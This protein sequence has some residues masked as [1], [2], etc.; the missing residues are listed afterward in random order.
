MGSNRGCRVTLP[1]YS[2]SEESEEQEA[3]L[4]LAPPVLPALQWERVQPEG[5]YQEASVEVL[6]DRRR[7]ASMLAEHEPGF[8]SSSAGKCALRSVK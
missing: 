3:G 4:P 5:E 2:S 6:E 8:A 1:G 7:A